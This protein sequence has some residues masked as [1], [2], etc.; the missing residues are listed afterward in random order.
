[1]NMKIQLPEILAIDTDWNGNPIRQLSQPQHSLEM[2]VEHYQENSSNEYLLTPVNDSAERILATSASSTPPE[3]FNKVLKIEPNDLRGHNSGFV[4]LSGCEWIRHP[5]IFKYSEDSIGYTE[6]LKDVINSWQGTFLYLCEDRDNK[7]KGLRP[8][9]IGAVHATHAHWT[10]TDKAATVVMPTGTGKTETMLSI[11]IS[12]QCEKLLVAVPTD[13]LR[14]QIAGKFLTL[15][16][17][18]DFGIVLDQGLYPIVGV[19]KHKPKNRDEVDTF[20]GR[21]NVVVTTMDIAGQCNTKVQEQMAHHCPFLFID[22]AHHL[23]AA[24]WKKLKQKFHKR[25]VLQFTATPF[26]NDNKPVEGEIIFN[27]PL[28]KAQK[29]GYFKHIHFKPVRVYDPSKV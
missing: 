7:V 17:L 20:F 12:K 16:I 2:I 18:K 28:S 13:P 23:G 26:R 25:K 14:T 4:N 24:T 3:K 1:M 8:P 21:C 11:L 10:V 19:L 29:E 27:Y 9:Q 22:E 15:G 5:E 6:R